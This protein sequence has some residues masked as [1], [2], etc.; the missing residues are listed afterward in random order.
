MDKKIITDP[1]I[2][3]IELTKMGETSKHMMGESR[4]DI[5]YT[6]ERGNYWIDT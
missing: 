6:D 1:F 5:I 3:E 2:G 4:F